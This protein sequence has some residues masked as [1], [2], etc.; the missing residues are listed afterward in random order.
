MRRRVPYVGAACA[1]VMVVLLGCSASST[2]IN[3][4]I[5]AGEDLATWEP[6]QQPPPG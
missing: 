1:V 6:D 3:G 4:K 2:T 5:I